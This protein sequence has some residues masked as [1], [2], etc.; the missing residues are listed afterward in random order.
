MKNIL[1]KEG[2]KQLKQKLRDLEKERDRLVTDMEEARQEGDLS[3][4]SAYHNLRENLTIV[5]NQIGD[6]KQRLANATISEK[7]GNGKVGVGNKVI[8]EVNGKE[9][10]LQVVGGG[11]ADPLKGKISYQSPIGSSLL[12]HKKGDS[13]QVDTPQGTNEYKIIEVK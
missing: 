4:N 11:E 10:V 6:I 9:K 2:Y 8:V 7:N 1:T 12:N 3:E 13:V 5:R